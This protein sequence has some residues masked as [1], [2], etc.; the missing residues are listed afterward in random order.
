VSPKKVVVAGRVS[1]GASEDEVWVPLCTDV[2][3]VADG[4]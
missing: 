2:V 3:V 1:T 4:V